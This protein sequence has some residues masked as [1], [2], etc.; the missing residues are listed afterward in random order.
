MLLQRKQLHHDA[1]VSGQV[2]LQ[3]LQPDCAWE[4]GGRDD[5]ESSVVMTQTAVSR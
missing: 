4:L 1:H 3:Y 5:A 2:N